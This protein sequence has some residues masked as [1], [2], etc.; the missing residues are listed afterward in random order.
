ML[1]QNSTLN[2]LL[3]ERT[4]LFTFAWSIVKDVHTAE[5]VFQEMM[6]KSMANKQAFENEFQLLGWARTVVRNRCFD[7]V[8]KENNRRNILEKSVIDLVQKDLDSRDM[9]KEERDIT[10]LKECI[11]TLTNNSRE[12]IKLRYFHSMQAIKVAEE[13][14]R[15]PDAVYKSLQRIYQK[16]RECMQA[17]TLQGGA[18]L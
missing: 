15:K 3:R 9:E 17:K 16:L 11:G 13:L 10:F 18:P 5:D 1:D 12:I 4:R 7:I 2:V 6:I 8:Y 14:Q